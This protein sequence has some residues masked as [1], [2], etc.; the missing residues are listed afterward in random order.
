MIREAIKQLS[1]RQDLGYET[2]RLVMDEIMEGKA[3]DVQ[4]SSFLTALS[5]KGETIEEI[6]ACAEGMRSHCKRLLH[7]MPV[8]EIVGTGGDHSNSFNISSTS[9][10]VISSCQVPV[11]K[12]GNRAA[13]SACGSADV[14][15]A[16]GVNIQV[17]EETSRRLLQEIGLC[18]LFAQNYHIS[19]RYVAPVRRE[20]GIRT[21]FNILG[22]LANP[23]GA[24]MQLMGVFDRSLLRPLAQVMTN[25]GVD[26]GMVVHGQDGMDEITLT[27]PTSVC[28]VKDGIFSEYSLTPE[29][30]GFNRCS[31]EDLLGGNAQENAAISRSILDGSLTGPK[32]DVVLFNSGCALYIAGRAETIAQGIALSAD[33]IDSGR[34]LAQLQKFIK[35]SNEE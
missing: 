6:T 32:R 24:S 12:H 13:S 26:R 19:M 7:E 10:I 21:V 4:M 31:K 14:F 33:A 5:L 34:A 27:A 25:L 20:L 8:L 2:A 23:A 3:S 16:L 1:Q 18:F 28:E 15:E 30:F 17:P 29:Q 9:S 35:L 22:P 11:A